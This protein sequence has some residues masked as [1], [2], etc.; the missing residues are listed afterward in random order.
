MN[1]RKAVSKALEDRGFSR[2]GRQHIQ[3]IKEGVAFWVD[4][5]PLNN[6]ADIAPYVGVRH[7]LVEELYTRFL[8][9]AQNPFVGTV[10]A[11]VGYILDLGYKAWHPPAQVPEVLDTIEDALNIFRR[12]TCLEELPGA[13]SIKGTQAPG[14]RFRLVVSWALLGDREKVEEALEVARTKA[15]R[16]EDKEAVQFRKFEAALGEYLEA[17]PYRCH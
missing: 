9:L 1:L 17:V 7:D 10:G 16:Y 8:G 15:C 5:G 6:R 3:N 14:W 4:T 13:W 2:D 11:N 12:F